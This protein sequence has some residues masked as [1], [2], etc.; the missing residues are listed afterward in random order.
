MGVGSDRA[1]PAPAGLTFTGRNGK[2]FYLLRVTGVRGLA[3]RPTDL[4]GG[5]RNS[6]WGWRLGKKNSVVFCGPSWGRESSRR[7]RA[8]ATSTPPGFAS[9]PMQ[10]Q[11]VIAGAIGSKSWRAW[12]GRTSGS[13]EYASGDLFAGV[14]RAVRWHLRTRAT[15]PPPEGHCPICYNTKPEDGSWQ[16][17]WCGCRVCSA[18][19]S[20]WAQAALDRAAGATLND[21]GSLTDAVALSCPA[22]SAPLRACDAANLLGGDS[23]LCATF[24]LALR[25]ARLRSMADFRPCPSCPGG[26]FLTWGCV[27]ANQQRAHGRAALA[28]IGLLVV[29]MCMGVKRGFTS[30]LSHREVLRPLCAGVQLRDIVLLLSAAVAHALAR[31]VRYLAASA[32]LGAPLHVGC[33]ECHANFALGAADAVGDAAADRSRLGSVA[34]DDAWVIEHTRPCPRCKVPILKH[35]GCNVMVCSRCRLTFCWACMQ[36]KRH[37]SHFA[38]ANGAPHGNASV[39]QAE[40]VT[41]QR[42]LERR[43][44]ACAATGHAA[45]AV[46][47][48]VAVAAICMLVLLHTFDPTG[49]QW[50][51]HIANTA[52][53]LLSSPMDCLGELLRRL[54]WLA[55]LVSQSVAVIVIASSLVLPMLGGGGV[56]GDQRARNQHPRRHRLRDM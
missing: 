56:A 35:G 38:C 10:N 25:D 40:L 26:G 11:H 39:W 14:C 31:A 42:Y 6:N 24:D 48:A 47:E 51:L 52:D 23:V 13:D 44:A 43:G 19:I 45:A 46:A 30:M 4:V 36:P 22:C 12:A 17:L 33:P 29:C 34:G 28:G 1:P 15:P 32:T 20:H 50:A 2:G 37:C 3:H 18:C 8:L 53:G 21:E 16:Q 54:T 49:P 9:S 41:D 5:V 55:R 7:V 27:G